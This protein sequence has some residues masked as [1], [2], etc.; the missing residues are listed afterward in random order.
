[1]NIAVLGPA[2]FG[3]SYLCVELINRGH[4]VAGISRSPEKLGAHELYSTISLDLEKASSDELA[5]A[6]KGFDVVIEYYLPTQFLMGSEYGPH[7][8]GAAAL[9][10]RTQHFPHEL[11]IEPFVELTRKVIL[12]IKLAK[13]PYFIKVGGTG[14]LYVPNYGGGHVTACDYPEFWRAYRHQIADSEAHT[15]YME[16]R[17]APIGVGLRQLRNARIAGREGRATKDD[18][19]FIADYEKKVMAQDDSLTFVRAGRTTF[20]FFDGNTSFKWSYASPPPMYRPGKRTGEYR[21]VKDVL[22]LDPP[23]PDSRNL[24]GRLLGITVADM[25]VAIADDAEKQE[26]AFTHWTAVGSLADDTP[27]PSYITLDSVSQ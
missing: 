27:A 22:P 10:Y 15:Q 19:T 2:G 24:E 14:S 13:V 17:L 25:A 21:V 6:F 11:T 7:T 1:L 8:A 26:N 16:E 5:D 20:M 9:V 23:G 4:H 12:A 3:G 18:L